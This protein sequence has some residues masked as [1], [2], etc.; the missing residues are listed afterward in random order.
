M[1]RKKQGSKASFRSVTAS[2]L[3]AKHKFMLLGVIYKIAGHSPKVVQNFCMVLYYFFTCY[4]AIYGICASCLTNQYQDS[5]PTIFPGSTVLTFV[6]GRIFTPLAILIILDVIMV[7]TLIVFC[8]SWYSPTK[9]LSLHGFISLLYH[10]PFLPIISGIVGFCICYLVET[11][12]SSALYAMASVTVVLYCVYVMFLVAMAFIEVLA[13]ISP[14]PHFAEWFGS[15][16]YIFPIIEGLISGFNFQKTRIDMVTWE[17]IA[18]VF[19][20]IEIIIATCMILYQP[21]MSILGNA[22]GAVKYLLMA[23]ATGLSIVSDYW[24]MAIKPWALGVIPILSIFLLLIAEWL[25]KR[26]MTGMEQI[27]GEL[28]MIDL[29]KATVTTMKETLDPFIKNERGYRSLIQ[30][31]LYFKNESVMSDVFIEYVLDRF[32]D[33]EWLLA[34]VVFVYCSL[35]DSCTEMYRFM[36]HLL[37]LDEFSIGC[38]FTLFQAIYGMMQVA[39]TESPIITRS[40]E[41]YKAIFCQFAIS[42]KLFWM[43]TTGSRPDVWGFGKSVYRLV[44]SFNDLTGKIDDLS[45]LYPYSATVQ[46]Y[47]ALVESDCKHNYLRAAKYLQKA[48]YMSDKG[49]SHVIQGA[50]DEY[51]ILHDGD[52]YDYEDTGEY[53]FISMHDDHNKEEK[54]IPRTIALS[55]KDQWLKIMAH[56]YKINKSDLHPRYEIL[57]GHLKCQKILIIIMILLFLGLFIWHLQLVIVLRDDTTDYRNLYDLI[58]KTVDLRYTSMIAMMDSIS[59]FHHINATFDPMMNGTTIDSDEYAFYL[60]EFQQIVGKYEGLRG[61]IDQSSN[62]LSIINISIEKCPFE[63]CTFGYI[64]G[65]FHQVMMYISESKTDDLSEF[66]EEYN[67]IQQYGPSLIQICSMIYSYLSDQL[68]NFVESSQSRFSPHFIAIIICEAVFGIVFVI[69]FIA[70]TRLCIFKM[71]SVINTI[72]PPVAKRIAVTFDS[73]FKNSEGQFHNDSFYDILIPVITAIMTSVVL[74]CFSVP[75]FVAYRK[76]SLAIDIPR[77]LDSHVYLSDVNE[78]RYASRNQKWYELISGT[79]NKTVNVTWLYELFGAGCLSAHKNFD[80]DLSLWKRASVFYDS[81]TPDIVVSCGILAGVLAFCVFVY[82]AYMAVKSYLTLKVSR[83][84]F[85]F[86]PIRAA[87]SNPAITRVSYGKPLTMNH[88]KEFTEALEGEPTAFDHFCVVYFSEDG[89]VEHMKGSTQ[90]LIGIEVDRIDTVREFCMNNTDTAETVER[91]FNEREQASQLRIASSEQQ[92]CMMVFTTHD[93]LVIVRSTEDAESRKKEVMVQNMCNAMSRLTE[94]EPVS[95]ESAFV[96]IFETNVLETR[97]AI[98]NTFKESLILYDTRQNRIVMAC[99]AC[100]AHQPLDQLIAM[101]GRLSNVKVIADIGSLNMTPLPVRVSYMKCRCSGA[102]YDDMIVKLGIMDSNEGLISKQAF[103]TM[104]M[105]TTEM[106]TKTL[107]NGP[108]E[109]VII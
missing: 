5:E 38:Q 4:S 36:L 109:Y 78:F 65:R 24:P 87:Q 63:R 21:I 13:M 104:G 75:M 14:N 103:D 68:S 29:E 86:I 105:D 10:I 88:V 72:Q 84:M 33:S 99:D 83:L 2:G 9:L 81:F 27:L 59:M 74:L 50:Y 47:R 53:T 66:Q 80:R 97:Q 57:S 94:N 22:L 26:R 37:S 40:L 12:E 34:Y 16:S 92:G 23:I 28:D 85:S 31:G 67:L 44:K 51:G 11:Q 90:D 32:P 41:S 73:I 19:M 20:G 18:G 82:T 100:K 101:K 70:I 93:T 102:L 61:W 7:F 71:M 96:V 35:K 45:R 58:N 62:Y 98:L 1:K 79:Y 76:R 8:V 89:T 49:A 43:S 107:V 77:S 91:F 42:H 69:Q 25:I 3:N 39:E 48:R 52:E 15:M 17:I 54:A 46:Y 30:V 56:T 106:H 55:L 108:N 64:Y 6:F 60:S 95:L